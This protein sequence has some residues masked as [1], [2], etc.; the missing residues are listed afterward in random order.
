[1]ESMACIESASCAPSVLRFQPT[2][3]PANPRRSQR[4]PNRCAQQAGAEDGDAFDHAVD[5][6]LAARFLQRSAHGR[7]DQA[8]LAHQLVELIEIESLRCIGCGLVGVGVHFH[9]D[10]VGARGHRRPGHGS[11]HIAAPG[12][13]RWIGHIGMCDSF[14]TT[15]I[16]E[17]SMVLRV[18]VS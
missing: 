18:A 14:L 13:V 5:S 8:Q 6:N 2:I 16:A 12:A 1:M 11:H 4:Q 7:G 17:M 3:E 15:G 9:E 10:S